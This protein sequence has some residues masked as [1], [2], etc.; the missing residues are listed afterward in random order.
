[1]CERYR[2]PDALQ[3]TLC[4]SSF[5]IKKGPAHPLTIDHQLLVRKCILEARGHKLYWLALDAIGHHLLIEK[6]HGAYRVYQAYVAQHTFGYTASQWCFGD[7]RN[8]P[9]WVKFGGGKLLMDKDIND[10][11]DLV[12]KWQKLT[13][14]VLRDVLLYAVPG[15]DPLAIPHLH[16][17]NAEYGMPMDV[18]G[19]AIEHVLKWSDRMINRIGPEGYTDIGVN[20]HD[21]RVSCGISDVDILMQ[22]GEPVF[23]IPANLYNQ[24]DSLNR[25]LTGEPIIP[26]VFFMMLNTGVWWESKTDPDTGSAVGFSF[27]GMD[28]DL[29]L[30]EEEGRMRAEKMKQAAVDDAVNRVTKNRK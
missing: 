29:H 30:S 4:L 14:T 27:R 2:L 23:S 9:A 20:P 24:C 26:S 11:L 12:G 17:S 10:L 7:M 8:K 3:L 19:P 5:Y 6:C 18:L 28:M 1:M 22:N 16:K 21:R 15:L 25:E 13:Q